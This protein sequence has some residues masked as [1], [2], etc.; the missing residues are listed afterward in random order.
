MPFFRKTTTFWVKLGSQI[1]RYI[2][3]CYGMEQITPGYMYLL[4]V[5]LYD[6]MD[7]T[8]YQQSHW[9]VISTTP[10]YHILVSLTRPTIIPAIPQAFRVRLQRLPSLM[11]DNC[12]RIFIALFA[13]LPQLPSSQDGCL[14]NRCTVDLTDHEKK[15]SLDYV[16]FCLKILQTKHAKSNLFPGDTKYQDP[17]CLPHLKDKTGG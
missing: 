12:L 2:R 7:N 9:T 14:A 4:S 11:R 10:P 8:I 17:L 16:P 1:F 15:I 13:N 6:S 3:P 5:R